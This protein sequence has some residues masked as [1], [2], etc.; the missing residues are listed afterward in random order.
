MSKL[1]KSDVYRHGN[2]SCPENSA[3]GYQLY[4][5]NASSGKK[6]YDVGQDL[7]FRVLFSDFAFQSFGILA[8]G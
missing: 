2:V 1:G 5:P 4:T 6:W 8:I 7:C 3:V